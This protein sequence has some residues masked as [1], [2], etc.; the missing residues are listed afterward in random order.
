MNKNIHA[1][2][3]KLSESRLQ[4]QYSDDND[5]VPFIL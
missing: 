3:K 5:T 4:T 2:G 1:L